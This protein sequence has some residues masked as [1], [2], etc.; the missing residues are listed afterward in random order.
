MA[1]PISDVAM[2]VGSGSVASVLPAGFSAAAAAGIPDRNQQAARRVADLYAR[3]V[4]TSAMVPSRFAA[5]GGCGCDPTDCDPACNRRSGVLAGG[6]LSS[7]TTDFA[8][9]RIGDF[10]IRH[11]RGIEAESVVRAIA[12]HRENHARGSEACV[13]WAPNASVS[14]VALSE[15][16]ASRSVAQ[17]EVSSSGARR[18]GARLDLAVKWCRWRGVRGGLSDAIYG[19]RASRSLQGASRLAAAGVRTAEPV[20][21]AERRRFGVPV[22]SFIITRFLSA[23]TPLPAALLDIAVRSVRRRAL[24]FALGDFVGTLHAAGV[25]HPDFK[26]S[27][28]LVGPGEEIALVDLDALV[29]NRYPTWR[30]RVRALGQLEAYATDLYPWLPRTDR[31]RFLRSY[32]ARNPELRERRAALVADVTVWV[33]RRL[34]S[35]ARKNRQ[36]HI[37]FPMAPR[38]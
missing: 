11:D 14:R 4:V 2:G 25:D 21:L 16:S 28:L 1:G 34:E 36:R 8:E 27:N 31:A 3:R 6:N 12:I 22:E 18:S 35:W 26:H 19:S 32:L 30:R 33:D 7:R 13:H 15:N 29:P 23:A 24:A 10:A 20:A 5:G 17:A 37:E 9:C 38:S